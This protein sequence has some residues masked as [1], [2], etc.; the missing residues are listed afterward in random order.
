MVHAR[1]F[2]LAFTPTMFGCFANLSS[3]GE[4]TSKPAAYVKIPFVSARFGLDSGCYIYDLR[5]VVYEHWKRAVVGD[6]LEVLAN[7]VLVQRKV[8]EARHQH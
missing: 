8:K 1:S 3:M 5:E 2:E 6:L 4:V 7:G